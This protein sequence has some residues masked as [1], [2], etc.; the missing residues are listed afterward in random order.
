MQVYFDN[1]ATTRPYPEV[2][3]IV[4]RMMDEDYGNPSSMHM[5]GVDAERYVRSAQ[6]TLAGLLRVK[7]KEIFFTSGGTEVPVFPV[8][9]T[10]SASSYPCMSAFC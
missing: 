1:A 5:K 7:P 4:R 3:E 9:L 8:R 6:E 10:S 2:R